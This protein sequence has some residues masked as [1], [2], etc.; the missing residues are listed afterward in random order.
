MV[1]VAV[2]LVKVPSSVVAFCSRAK[3]SSSMAVV[4]VVDTCFRMM[5]AMRATGLV[6]AGRLYIGVANSQLSSPGHAQLFNVHE[7][8]GRAGPRL[9][10][11]DTNHEVKSI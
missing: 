2:A 1:A 6:Y 4:D 9:V 5:V 10:C 11:D 8:S 3:A 7:K